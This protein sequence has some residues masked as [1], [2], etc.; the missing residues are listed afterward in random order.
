[1][2]TRNT[3]IAL[4]LIGVMASG[5]GA[6]A[7]DK[8]RVT[9]TTSVKVEG[10]VE[11]GV[12]AAV[13]AEQNALIAKVNAGTMTADQAQAEYDAFRSKVAKVAQ[14]LTVLHDALKT[15]A[16]S[17]DAADALG[18]KDYGSV[19]ADVASAIATLVQALSDAGIHIPG[20]Q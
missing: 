20:V 1:M 7:L 12:L 13:T 8:A 5:C 18:S 3:L 4:S 16:H 14:A 9:V 10:D 17:I 11:D 2:R 19:M 15:A 6:S